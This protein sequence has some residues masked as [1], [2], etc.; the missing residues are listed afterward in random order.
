VTTRAIHHPP[1]ASPFASS[2]EPKVVYVHCRTPFVSAIKRV[3]KLL[4]ETAKREKQS[5]SSQPGKLHAKQVEKAIADAAKLQGG[6]SKRE[7]VYIKATGRAIP[8]AL[9]IGNYFQ[10]Q[11]D[12][13]VMLSIGSVDVVDDIEIKSPKKEKDVKSGFD[14]GNHNEVDLLA[15]SPV[16]LGENSG[17]ETEN[18]RGKKRK[19]EDIPEARIRTLPSVEVAVSLR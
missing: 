3:R 17:E 8:R 19:F 18:G 14:D 11:S 1:I 9:E 6:V 13:K 16:G 10:T 2:S 5:L 4:S 7:E 15:P 12:C